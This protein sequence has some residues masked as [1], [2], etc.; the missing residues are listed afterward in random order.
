M[1]TIVCGVYFVHQQVK[2]VM[3]LPGEHLAGDLKR[4]SLDS[5]FA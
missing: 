4:I 5:Q 2:G 3:A 1:R